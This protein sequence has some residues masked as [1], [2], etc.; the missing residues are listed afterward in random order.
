MSV[1]DR[2]AIYL[3]ALG[4][5]EQVVRDEPDAIARQAVIAA[6]LFRE[7]NLIWV[8]F[9]RLEDNVLVLGP[10]QGPPVCTRIAL[11]AGVCGT[12]ARKQTP[13]IVPDV[14]QFPG[15]IQGSGATQS[16]ITVPLVVE[17]GVRLILDADSGEIDYFS[18]IDADFF[19]RILSALGEHV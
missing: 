13:V 1:D 17:G 12:A 7:L 11:S 3:R 19:D 5:I 18:Q 8:G 14:R 16:E 9:Y 4:E 2:N 15:Y 6:I 10:F